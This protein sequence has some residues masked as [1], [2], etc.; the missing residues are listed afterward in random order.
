[1]D[2]RIEVVEDRT[3]LARCDEG[4]IRVRRYR[5]VNVSPDGSRSEPYSYDVVERRH[6]DAVAMALYDPTPP[7]PRI[8]L[9]RALRPPVWFRGDHPLPLPEHGRRAHVLELPAGLVEDAEQ[10]QTGIAGCASRETREETGLVV[11]A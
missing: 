3:A 1:M 6:M 4:F 10:G 7:E 11:P 8:V 9:R 5:L 2:V